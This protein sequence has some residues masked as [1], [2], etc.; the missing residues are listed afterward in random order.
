MHFAL[1]KITIK[2]HLNAIDWYQN[3]E[4][5][6]DCD[7]CKP[8]LANVQVTSKMAAAAQ[9]WHN[10]LSSQLQAVYSA[11]QSVSE[12]L[13]VLQSSLILCLFDSIDAQPS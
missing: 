8:A 13:F 1:C 9:Q 4:I 7:L 5:Y 2:N 11:A 10:F 3:L 6:S 12:L